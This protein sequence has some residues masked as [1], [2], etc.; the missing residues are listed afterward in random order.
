MKETTHF[1]KANKKV[2]HLPWLHVFQNRIQSSFFRLQGLQWVTP[3]YLSGLSFYHLCLVH[4]A[5][6]VAGNQRL[7]RTSV[8]LQGLTGYFQFL[9][10]VNSCCHQAVVHVVSSVLNLPPVPTFFLLNQPM[11]SLREKVSNLKCKYHL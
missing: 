10:F 8:L 7:Q 1:I 4:Y 9:K 11:L 6:G 3:S 5:Q 2:K